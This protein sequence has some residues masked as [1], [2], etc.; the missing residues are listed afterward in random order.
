MQYTYIMAQSYTI[1]QIQT[2][3]QNE[4]VAAC[5]SQVQKLQNEKAMLNL[6]KVSAEKRCTDAQATFD[7][8]TDRLAAIEIELVNVNSQLTVDMENAM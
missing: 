8:I 4:T 1:E 6:K 2:A 5:M 3:L 7:S